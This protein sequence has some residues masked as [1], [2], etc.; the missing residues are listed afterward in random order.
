MVKTPTTYAEWLNCF[1]R[2]RDE[3]FEEEVIVAMKNGTIEW[4]SGV[5]ERFTK[6][7]FDLIDY[8][9]EFIMK[10]M[11]MKFSKQ[12]KSKLEIENALLHTRRSLKKLLIFSSMESIPKDLRKKIKKYIED[13]ADTIQSAILDSVERDRIGEMVVLVKNNAVNKLYDTLQV[14]EDSKEELSK[15]YQEKN[16]EAEKISFSPKRRILI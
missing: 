6:S 12:L 13:T 2:F 4:Q 8:K 7:L 14:K 1:D 10:S 9:I 11:N 5:A 16:D 3:Q 15:D